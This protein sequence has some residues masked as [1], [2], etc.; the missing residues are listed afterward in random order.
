MKY[1][2]YITGTIGVSFD[3]W[4]GQQGTTAKQV[5]NFLRDH[6]DD[7]LTIAVSS[8][9]GYLDEG[10]TIAE[11]IKAHGKC[12]MVIVGMTASA[13]TVLCMKAKSVKIAKGS[14]MLI[15][16]SSYTL[17]VWTSANKHGV[18]ELIASFKK[19]RDDLDTFD[20]AIA[21]IYSS[22][23]GKSL[24]EN[25]AQ[26]DKEQ[27]MRAEEAVDFG[28]VDGIID[29]EETATQSKAIK[30]VYASHRGLAD[31]FGLPQIPT[32]EGETHSPLR[33]FRDGLRSI[34]SQMKGIV[35]DAELLPDA[36]Q[37]QSHNHESVN[38][39]TISNNL[40]PNDM[41]TLILNLICAALGIQAF[42]LSDKGETTLTEEQLQKLE[43]ELKTRDTRISV[44]EAEKQSAVDAKTQAEADKAKAEK[45]L[46]DLQ[47]EF[48]DFKKQAGDESSHIPGG[49]AGQ[50]DAPKKS[51]DMYNE[52][53]DLLD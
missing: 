11:L 17:D 20:K 22:R 12:N 33:R 37:Q 1:D 31:H 10:I 25:L 7:E 26:M 48:A 14:M 46:A 44:L 15:H 38:D 23:N 34:M 35:N 2:F 47:E 24:D 52:I 53:K 13:A 4:T 39:T 9:G 40:N 27:W 49:A 51:A 19:Y 30:N 5:R 8:P 42:S 18:D 21:E 36:G 29:D 45:E 41:K 43:N 3:W 16:N 32:E 28:L 50:E 6:Q